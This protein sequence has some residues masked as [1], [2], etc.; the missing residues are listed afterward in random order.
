MTFFEMLAGAFA[1]LL[2]GVVA[3]IWHKAD[4]AEKTS[5]ANRMFLEQFL[6][7]LDK[8]AQLTERLSSLEASVHAE[9]KNISVSIK[10]MEATILRFESR[11]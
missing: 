5:D 11:K 3:V 2:S 8:T 1:A 6:K 9:I 10:R 7:N 4:R